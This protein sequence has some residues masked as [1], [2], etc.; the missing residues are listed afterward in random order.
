MSKFGIDVSKWQGDIDWDKVKVDFAILKL[1]NIG[2]N[3]K[4]WAD[5]KFERNYQECQRLGIPVGVYVY[6]YTNLHDNAKLAGEEVIKYLNGRTLQLP[7]YI[8][9]E[10]K[11][12][13]GEGKDR[14]EQVIE[15]F[16]SVIEK[17]YK[18]GVYAN[19]NWFNNYL[20]KEAIKSKYTTWIASYKS[21]TN[22]Y[23]GEYDMWQN[24]SSGHIEGING[25]VDTNY[26]YSDFQPVQPQP[27]QPIQQIPQPKLYSIGLYVVNTP[28][29]LNVRSGAGT[30][31]S[32]VKVYPNGTRFDALEIQGE[33]ARTPSGWVN[34]KY[35]KLAEKSGYTRGLYV[36]NTSA[37]LNV[38]TGA[39]TNYKVV[40]TYPNG[41][42]FDTYEIRGEWARTPSGWVN[43][44]YCKLVR[45]Y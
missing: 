38:R 5:E 23:E 12:I 11:E 26:L 20:D 2:D 21:G 33:W 39:G 27:I 13:V 10:D 9:M 22:C 35:C 42:R 14:L 18:A 1:G 24:S 8:D 31:Y 45:Q 43:L 17:N 16:N 7:V 4:F 3:Q 37:G 32:V 44:K 41:T 29:G 19:E 40:K 34:L 36:V 30:N 6:C 15:N 25:N 28:A